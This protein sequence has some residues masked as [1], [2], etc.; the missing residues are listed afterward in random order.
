[1]AT[2][3]LWY[4]KKH[5]TNNQGQKGGAEIFDFCLQFWEEIVM[6]VDG[7]IELSITDTIGKAKT[8]TVGRDVQ[9]RVR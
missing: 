2:K 8:L 1:V 5:T 6:N 4:G 9:R 3:L 7:L